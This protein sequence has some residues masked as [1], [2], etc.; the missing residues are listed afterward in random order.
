[1][2]VTKKGFEEGV[3]TVFEKVAKVFDDVGNQLSRKVNIAGFIL[4]LFS[5]NASE[6]D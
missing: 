3:A 6:N 2:S 5:S 1:M 4:L